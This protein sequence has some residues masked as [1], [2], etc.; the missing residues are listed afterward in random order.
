MSAPHCPPIHSEI[1]KVLAIKQD[2]EKKAIQRAIYEKIDKDDRVVKPSG[3]FYNNLQGWAMFK[4][5]Y[6]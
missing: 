3:D 5:A 2:V 6:Y 4:L 1:K